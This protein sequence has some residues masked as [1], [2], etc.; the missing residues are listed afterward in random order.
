MALNEARG[1]LHVCQSLFGHLILLSHYLLGGGERRVLKD[2]GCVMIELDLIPP[3]TVQH[4][5]DPINCQVIDNKFSIVR[6]LY[7]VGDN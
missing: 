4:S 1:R 6:H 5:Y 7:F 2:L 3:K